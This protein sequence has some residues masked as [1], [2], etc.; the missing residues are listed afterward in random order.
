MYKMKEN[1][2]K[3]RKRER[4]IGWQ[5]FPF[6]IRRGKELNLDG[7]SKEK[8]LAFLGSW[9]WK[10]REQLILRQNIRVKNS[11]KKTIDLSSAWYADRL[12]VGN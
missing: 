11:P 9:L 3:I 1:Q 8:V 10:R 4:D 7:L 2:K 6:R 5:N 12:E